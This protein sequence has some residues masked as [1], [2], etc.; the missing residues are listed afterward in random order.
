MQQLLIETMQ[1]LLAEQRA[2]E[3]NE[4][5][6]IYIEHPGAEVGYFEHNVVLVHALYRHTFR[7]RRKAGDVGHDSTHQASAGRALSRLVAQGAVIRVWPSTVYAEVPCPCCGRKGSH[8]RG[9]HAF[10]KTVAV[11]LAEDRQR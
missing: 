10:K 3:F 7:R 1:D 6:D 5:S 2:R 8:P 4:R 9:A 11:I